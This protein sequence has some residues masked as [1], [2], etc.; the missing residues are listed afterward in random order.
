VEAFPRDEIADK[1]YI[2]RTVGKAP[3]PNILPGDAACHRILPRVRDDKRF[4][5][6]DQG[7]NCG[8]SSEARE[9]IAI[10]ALQKMTLHRAI[11]SILPS[12]SHFAASQVM[13]Y[14]NDRT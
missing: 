7:F 8:R 1:Q 4:F 10:D 9:N 5:F 11:Q 2:E 13:D 6:C 14:G 3:A 12:R